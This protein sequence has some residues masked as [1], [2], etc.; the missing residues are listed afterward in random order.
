M[1]FIYVNLVHGQEQMILMKTQ[2]WV[3]GAFT[4]I[5]QGTVNADAGFVLTTDGSITIGSTS[6]SFSQFSEQDK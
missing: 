6:L 3:T 1:V 2:D 4:F 5:E